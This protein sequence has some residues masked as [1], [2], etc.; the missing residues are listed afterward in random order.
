MQVS[1]QTAPS[2]NDVRPKEPNIADQKARQEK[3]EA[4]EAKPREDARPKP[5]GMGRV[6]DKLA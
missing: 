2:V 6:V 4:V 5:E 1:A 3:A